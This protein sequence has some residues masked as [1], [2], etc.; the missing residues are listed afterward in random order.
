MKYAVFLN[1]KARN[2]SIFVP[3]V[4]N[5]KKRATPARNCSPIAVFP[6]FKQCKTARSIRAIFYSI[7][8]GVSNSA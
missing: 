5:R 2:V 8:K 3:C 7:K 1:G 6:V 4:C